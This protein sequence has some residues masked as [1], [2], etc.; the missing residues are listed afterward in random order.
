MPRSGTVDFGE[1]AVRALL[2]QSIDL[3]VHFDTI[4]MLV[5]NL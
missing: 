3:P 5:Y 1:P 2:A 4:R